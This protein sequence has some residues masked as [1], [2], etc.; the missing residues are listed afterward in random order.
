MGLNDEHLNRLVHA[1]KWIGNSITPSNVV[2][3]TDQHGGHISC[4]TESVVSCSRSMS[5]IASG[6]NEIAESIN[7]LAEAI[8]E[9]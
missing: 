3:G 7:N 2:G 4:L 1:I 5:E 9:K 8:R 6:L